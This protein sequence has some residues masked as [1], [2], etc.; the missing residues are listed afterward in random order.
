MDSTLQY[1]LL[2]NIFKYQ[3]NEWKTLPETIS[4]PSQ[5]LNNHLAIIHT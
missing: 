1:P 5:A 3:E 4:F 2:K